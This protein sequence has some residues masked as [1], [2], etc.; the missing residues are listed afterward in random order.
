LKHCDFTLEYNDSYETVAVYAT[1]DFSKIGKDTSVEPAMQATTRKVW[2][3]TFPLQE[4]GSEERT[5]IF[6]IWNG[7]RT[8]LESVQFE[9]VPAN[10]SSCQHSF[11]AEVVKPGTCTHDTVLKYTCTCCDEQY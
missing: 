4:E 9:Y 5:K 3:G 2:I 11:T 8:W 10:E 1:V 7:D 6:G